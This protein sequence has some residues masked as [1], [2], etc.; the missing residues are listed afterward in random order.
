MNNSLNTY[1]WGDEWRCDL[2]GHQVLPVDWREEWMVLQFKLEEKSRFL[3][4]KIDSKQVLRI[5]KSSTCHLC[6]TFSCAHL[7]SHPSLPASWCGPSAGAPQAVPCLS[8]THWAW[9]QE[10][11]A[12]CCCTSQLCCDCRTGAV[13]NNNKS[14][15]FNIWTNSTVEV[16]YIK[17][18]V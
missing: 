16:R 3:I 2:L 8:L 18:Q 6:L 13:N 9:A 5:F 11:C 17:S 12:G 1:H 10:P 4:R 7:Q 15:L 14:S